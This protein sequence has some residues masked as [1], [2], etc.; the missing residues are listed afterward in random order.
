MLRLKAVS[1]GNWYK[2]GIVPNRWTC[3]NHR[4]INKNCHT[5]SKLLTT[6][7]RIR[8]TV[9]F[10]ALH[11]YITPVSSRPP[12]RT[13]MRQRTQRRKLDVILII[14]FAIKEEAESKR[15]GRA[16]ALCFQTHTFKILNIHFL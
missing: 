13:D 9:F 16:T 4:I 10:P 3:I 6:G 8:W 12:I 11:Y 5:A 2:L 15:N 7:P 14:T 1:Q